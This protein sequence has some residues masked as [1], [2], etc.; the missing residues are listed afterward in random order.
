[1]SKTRV[2]ICLL[3]GVGALLLALAAAPAMATGGSAA[4]V[5]LGALI[6][7]DRSLSAPDGQSC[8][9]CHL[10]AAGYAD[11]DQ[12]MPVSQ[13]V[14]P[15]DFGG[16][17][18]PTWAYT[19][20]TPDLHP[21]V[22]DE[23]GVTWIGGMFWDGRATG[24]E[25]S[26]L[27]EQARGPFLN[28]VEMQNPSEAEVIREVRRAPYA[29]LFRFVF[30]RNSLRDVDA[31]YDDVARAIAAYESSRLVNTF[32]SRYDAYMA[33]NSRAL[34]KQ[35]KNGLALFNGKGLCNQCHPSEPGPYSTG[36]AKGKALFTDYTY[37]NL[38]IPRNPA[39]GL[40]PLGDLTGV[41]NGLG[42][43]LR[44]TAVD[45]DPV[46][47][48]SAYAADADGLFKVSTLRNLTSTAPYGHNGYFPTLK[49]IVHFYNTRDVDPM[50][51]DAEVPVNVNVDELGN[52]GL[53][54]AEEDAIVAFMKTL[55]D[56]V[57]VNIP[58][59]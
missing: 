3:L 8:A 5:A 2:R 53:T 52:L 33:G 51:P 20:W 18:A 32:S 55:T 4:K 13:G 22:D 56:R 10:P 15:A 23:G 34:N 24:W 31:A 37:D 44:K 28:P 14:D 1:M 47:D 36:L 19:A 43:F 45:D 11:P 50:W 42:D 49:S 26:P 39:F 30:G 6:A 16:R 12:G 57:V 59:H 40:P 38:G 7:G 35:E 48:Y 58:I 27:V 46:H 54:N 9:D 21:E 17:N 29:G 25:L 41:D